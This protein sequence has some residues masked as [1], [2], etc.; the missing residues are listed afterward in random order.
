MNRHWW[1][2]FCHWREEVTNIDAENLGG[3]VCLIQEHS[4][5]AALEIANA[6]SRE[7]KP[8]PEFLL[9]EPTAAP[10]FCQSASE[11]CVDTPT[12]VGGL[13]IALAWH[14][15]K[16]GSESEKSSTSWHAK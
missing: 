13:P 14:G 7:P 6:G 1:E 10:S 5:G 12:K 9:Q 4:A 2:H 15:Q 3:L 16:I 11:C 8:Y